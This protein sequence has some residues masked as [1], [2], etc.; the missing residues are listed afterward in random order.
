ML[1]FEVAIIKCN[2]VAGIMNGHCANDSSI[3]D[4]DGGK[5]VDTIGE[6]ALSGVEQLL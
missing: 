5:F 6:Q 1:P 2:I 4:G 3:E